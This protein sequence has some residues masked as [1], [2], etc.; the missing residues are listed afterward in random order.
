MSEPLRPS[1]MPIDWSAVRI[2][3]AAAT[4][5][6]AASGTRSPEDARRLLEHRARMLA[7]P[8]AP[9]E[10]AAS[11]LIV[12]LCSLGA[13]RYALEARWVREVP[14]AVEVT[15]LPGTPSFVAGVMPWRGDLLGVFHLAGV[16]QIDAAPPARGR[17]VVLGTNRTE[18]ALLV[19]QVEQVIQLPRSAVTPLPPDPGRG[20]QGY[21]LGV[22]AEGIV[23]LDGER[24]LTDPRLFLNRTETEAHT[25]MD[26]VGGGHGA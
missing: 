11:R 15:P 2:R 24:L 4:A 19:E 9:G 13:G 23:V 21:L 8:A 16:L 20:D 7:R 17:V 14:A 1:R 12:L 6:V 3:L 5:A 18:Y 26:L 10:D 25:P 22:T